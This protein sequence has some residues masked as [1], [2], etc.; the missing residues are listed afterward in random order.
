MSDHQDFE[1]GLAADPALT[2]AILADTAHFPPVPRTPA[3]VLIRCDAA[4]AD[5]AIARAFAL[6]ILYGEV[7]DVELIGD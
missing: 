7:A 4:H 6:A 2:D 3:R 1:R 5:Q